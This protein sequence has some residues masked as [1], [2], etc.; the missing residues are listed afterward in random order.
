MAQFNAKTIEPF[1]KGAKWKTF[2]DQLEAFIILNDVTEVKTSVLLITQFTAEVYGVLKAAVTPAK[3]LTM[4]Y[5]TLKTKLEELYAP[6]DN[7]HF[8]R[9][10]F[11]G[12]RQKEDESIDEFVKALQMLS[13]DLEWE[14]SVQLAKTVKL[15]D[16]KAESLLSPQT[17][18]QEATEAPSVNAIWHVNKRRQQRGYNTPWHRECGASGFGQGRGTTRGRG[19][20]QQ[21]APSSN[22]QAASNPASEECYYRGRKR[23]RSYQCSLRNKYFSECGRQGY[24]HK[25]C[26]RNRYRPPAA[27]QNFI[28]SEQMTADEMSNEEQ[29]FTSDHCPEVEDGMGIYMYMMKE[30]AT[31]N[32]IGPHRI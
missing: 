30:E 4:L 16:A 26:A 2:E 23:H 25:T 15:A 13:P 18:K 24:I 31:T 1:K 21:R 7:I 3:P 12:R 6:K 29:R 8:A 20:L 17:S 5:E 27:N 22:A 32:E 28:D 19:N 10:T 14:Q 9:F 11:R